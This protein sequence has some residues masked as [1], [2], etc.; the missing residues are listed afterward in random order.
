MS[1]VGIIGAF[2]SLF[3]VFYASQSYGRF[4]Q[5]YTCVADAQARVG[6]IVLLATNCIQQSSI[7]RSAAHRIM[8]HVNAMH[9][10]SYVGLGETAYS[11][12]NFLRP[13]N[14]RHQLLTKQEYERVLEIG[15]NADQAGSAA[16]DEVCS[17]LLRDI[18][19]ERAEDRLGD[20]EA[21]QLRGLVLKLRDQLGTL[22]DFAAQ[23]IPF[24]YVHLITIISGIYLPLFAY[25]VAID[26]DIPQGREEP[27]APFQILSSAITAGASVAA[28][29]LSIIG[30]QEVG[31]KLG[32][33]F[34]NDLVDLPVMSFLTSTLASTRRIVARPEPQP[35][36]PNA[37]AAMADIAYEAMIPGTHVYNE[38][39]QQ[40][41]QNW[42]ANPPKSYECSRADFDCCMSD[43]DGA[44]APLG[45][46]YKDIADLSNDLNSDGKV[47]GRDGVDMNADGAITAAD[48]VA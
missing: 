7:G 13:F 12:Q 46:E 1:K 42:E 26:V 38:K 41:E 40:W 17:W 35:L 16:S 29:C 14:R 39:M 36:F 15:P 24:F 27:P 10:L 11:E 28:V 19:V 31:N 5:Q 45:T 4:M 30:L 20:T 48:N 47:D 34:G 43:V 6:D 33:P 25:G 22:A 18:Q 37:E 9:V 23:P 8:R 44:F 2:H 21:D 3:L 32:D